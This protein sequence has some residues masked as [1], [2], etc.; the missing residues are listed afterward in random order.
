M[1]ATPLKMPHSWLGSRD[2]CLQNANMTRLLYELDLRERLRWA[3][4]NLVAHPM[5]V[6]LPRTWGEWLHEVTTPAQHEHR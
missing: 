3:F 5:S 4:H 2:E 6:F 1:R